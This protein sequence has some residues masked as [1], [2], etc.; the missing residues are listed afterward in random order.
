[1]EVLGYAGRVLDKVG[2]RRRMRLYCLDRGIEACAKGGAARNGARDCIQG[3]FGGIVGGT[4][5][6]SITLCNVQTMECCAG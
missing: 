2:G 4:G 3:G 1:M 5:G 6:Y